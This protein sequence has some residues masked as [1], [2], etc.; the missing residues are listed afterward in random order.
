[1]I[2]IVCMSQ[3]SAHHTSIPVVPAAVTDC[4]PETRTAHFDTSF[5]LIAASDKSDV[6]VA[7][8][9]TY[10]YKSISNRIAVQRVPNFAVNGDNRARGTDSLTK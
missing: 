4:T 9:L 3:L 2:T 5:K 6:T 7:A 8:R 1:M 10:V